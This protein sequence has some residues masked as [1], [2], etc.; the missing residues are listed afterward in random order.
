[1]PLNAGE[2]DR[3]VTLQQLTEAVGSSGFPQST[4]A[5]MSESPVWASRRDVMAG[6]RFK[7]NQLSAS[8]AVAWKIYYREDMD[9]E[10]VDVPKRR[11]LVYQ[12]RIYDIVAG[13]LLGFNEGIELMTLASMRVA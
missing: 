2:M 13:A 8:Q 4:W 5:E 3:E 6:E 11:R 1:M 9:P 7:A 12:G 10:S